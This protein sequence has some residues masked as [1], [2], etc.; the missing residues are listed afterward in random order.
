MPTP[1]EQA[2]LLANPPPAPTEEELARLREEF[3]AIPRPTPSEEAA[4]RRDAEGLSRAEL[5]ELRR[6]SEASPSEEEL[7]TLKRTR[8]LLEELDRR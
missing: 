1:E 7:E 4:M 6:A 5:E 2:L 8:D 3:D